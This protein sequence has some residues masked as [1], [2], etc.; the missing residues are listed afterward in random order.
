MIV[1]L[2]MMVTTTMM[3]TTTFT[4]MGIMLM[5][6]M[7]FSPAEAASHRD[8]LGPTLGPSI[9]FRA[10]AQFSSQELAEMF[11]LALELGRSFKDPMALGTFNVGFINRFLVLL[12]RF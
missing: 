1:M 12:L 2:V 7:L 11:N 10:L 5:R 9:D 3:I 6:M 4:V 8:S